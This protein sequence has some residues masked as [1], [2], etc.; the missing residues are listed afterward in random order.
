MTGTGQAMAHA[1]LWLS[2]YAHDVARVLNRLPSQ[3]QEVEVL[4][5]LE[6]IR[7]QSVESGGDA[8]RL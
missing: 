2:L 7:H 3:T 1:C 6:T 8:T 4:N 5:S